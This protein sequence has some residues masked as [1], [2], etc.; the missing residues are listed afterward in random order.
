MSK[1]IGCIIICIGVLINSSALGQDDPAA[2]DE[3]SITRVGTTAAQFLKL[4]VGARAISLGGAYVA[5][6]NDMSAVYWNP[7]GFARLTGR[8][9]QLSNTQYLADVNYNFAAFGTSID[10]FGSIGLSL[11]M[12]DSGDMAVRTEAQPEGTGEQF[13][14]LSFA[15]QV[16][17]AR[18]LSSQFSLGANIKLIQE[19]IWHSKASAIAFDIGTLFTTPFSSLRLGASMS[20]I[21]PKLRMEGRDILFSEDPSPNTVGTAE[22]V[23]AQYRT[24]GFSMP[25]IFRVGLAWDAINNGTHRIVLMTDA[26]HPNDNAEYVNAGAEYTFRDLISFRAG[27]RNLF[28]PDTEQGITAGGS[29]MIRI[30]RDLATRFD[31]AYADFGR[32]TQ[33]HWFTF[34]L[35]F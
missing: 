7:A 30:N 28:E 8:H 19:Q 27:Y 4:G 29:L 17:Y 1:F 10:R 24:D 16:S 12:V 11:L 26:T 23:N 33:T 25:L 9:L 31:Y 32:L 6:A 13:N 5:E 14:T 15:L 2:I 21:G 35:S 22:I 34:N 3:G 20:N 18:N